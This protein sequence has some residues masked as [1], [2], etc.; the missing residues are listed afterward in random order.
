MSFEV[1]FHEH[2]RD[3][4][5]RR[6]LIVATTVAA[7][8]FAFVIS[9][10]L[11]PIYEAKATFYVAANTGSPRFVGGPEA[12][13]EPL[14]PTPD[15]KTAA[16]NVGILRGKE[17][18]SA[19]AREFD[20]PVGLVQKRVDV[21][22]SGEFMVDV[23][24]R[25]EDPDRAA[26]M[27]NRA[28]ALYAG[29][30]EASMRARAADVAGT[31]RGHIATLETKLAALS[32]QAEEQRRRFGTTVDEALVER[33][34]ATQATAER[35]LQELDGALAAALA[36]RKELEAELTLERSTYAA[37]D[38]VLT[39]PV[40]DLMVEQLL[41]LRVDLAEVRDGPQSARRSAI[42][43]QMAEIE[44][45][46]DLE[47]QRMAQAVVKSTGSHYE[48]LRSS[49]ATA[50]A[51]EAALT[52]SR[53]TAEAQLA[54]ARADLDAA[55]S[56]LA[57]AERLSRQTAEIES[58]ITDARVNLASAELQAANAK[59]PLVV[60]E[61]ASPPTRPAFPLPVLNA[62][63]AVM[64]GAV[65]G[66]YYALF[67]GHSRRARLQRLATSLSLPRFTDAE[68]ARLRA[69]ADAQT[70]EEGTAA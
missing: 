21:T 26:A 10:V 3:I 40:L 20:L 19:L 27:A 64:T 17:F 60:V 1:P 47:R 46:I 30:H 23:F 39:T 33:L 68:L 69:L 43:E 5:A 35:R 38:I 37:G 61:T 50:K 2:W 15:E 44:R 53:G 48:G 7:G 54:A 65:I 32:G 22:V 62:I 41:A 28:P 36:R 25:S 52:A 8:V 55:I 9:L 58:Q 51:D 67:L 12:P 16:L 57:A 29:F 63:V 66:F 24:V 31:L 11:T 42:E 18:M 13:P 34:S 4:H 49:I 14:F 59:A 6:W 45:A 70:V 56:A